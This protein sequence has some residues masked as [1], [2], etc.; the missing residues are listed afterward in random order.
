[1]VRHA[2]VLKNFLINMRACSCCA[3]V[4]ECKW[5]GWGYGEKESVDAVEGGV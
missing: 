5:G 3:Y 2:W 4:D 1:M